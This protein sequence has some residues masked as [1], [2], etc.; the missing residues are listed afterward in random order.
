LIEAYARFLGVAPGQLVAARGASELLWQLA[1]SPLA[2]RVAVP[3]PAYTEYRQ[4][5]PSAGVGPAGVHHQLDLVAELLAAGR[6]VL[7]SNPH[8]PSG[9]AFTAAD[10]LSVVTSTSGRGVLIVDESYIEFADPATHSVVGC[11]P[12]NLAVLRSPSKFFGL[13]GA[14][15]GVAWSTNTELLAALTVRRGSWPVSAL[16]VAPVVAALGDR[17]W[18]VE[19]HGALQADGAWL[20]QQVATAWGRAVVPGAVTHF[21]LVSLRDAAAMSGR[22]AAAGVAVRL[23]G[24]AHGLG[25]PAIRIAAP[26]LDER[27]AVAAVLAEVADRCLARPSSVDLDDHLDLDRHVEG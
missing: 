1:A 6:V 25:G 10:L 8:N 7:I 9:R 18:Q 2:A 15:V 14:R 5:F 3:L 21:R 22:L 19:S 4:A 26:R 23:L 13:A 12:Q 11:A 17:C 16:E 20:E 27:L 24:R